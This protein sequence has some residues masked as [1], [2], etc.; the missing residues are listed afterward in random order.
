M[1]PEKDISRTERWRSVDLENEIVRNHIRLV[2]DR[3]TALIWDV[4]GAGN[5]G[6]VV[7]IGG[8]WHAWLRLEGWNGS[9]TITCLENGTK[10]VR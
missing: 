5:L 10:P 8:G 6:G 2:G 7:P 4:V 9:Q 1:G 3:E